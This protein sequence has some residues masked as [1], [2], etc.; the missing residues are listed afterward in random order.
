MK[1]ARY[2]LTCTV[3]LVACLACH[4]VHAEEPGNRFIRG[5]LAYADFHASATAAMGGQQVLGG[6]S[7]VRHNIGF[8]FETGYYLVPDRSVALTLGALPTAKIC[9]LTNAGKLAEATCDPAVLALQYHLPTH[10]RFQP[11]LN[12][13][14][15]GFVQTLARLIPAT[16]RVILNR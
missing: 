12:L 8:A 15:R 6:S 14:A 3:A 9:S 5:G 2:A 10:G 16:S 1:T 13:D 11:Y 4:A 7:T